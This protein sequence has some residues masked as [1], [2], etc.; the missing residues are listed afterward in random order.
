MPE[1]LK[2]PITTYGKCKSL[3]LFKQNGQ[4]RGNRTKQNTPN[5]KVCCLHLESVLTTDRDDKTHL[6]VRSY[7]ATS[8][9]CVVFN[10]L[11]Y[12]LRN[13]ARLFNFNSCVFKDQYS[14][15]LGNSHMILIAII[16]RGIVYPHLMCV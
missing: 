5:T 7:V 3:V 4:S 1:R 11:L 14:V 15:I 16:P 2:Q 9:D 13:K 8:I 10:L 6:C 12:Y